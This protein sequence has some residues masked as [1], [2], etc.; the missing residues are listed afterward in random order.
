MVSPVHGG[1]SSEAKGG[2]AVNI[3]GEI[4]LSWWVPLVARSRVKQLEPM[5][6]QPQWG[7]DIPYP[8]VPLKNSVKI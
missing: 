4:L 8:Q 5:T 3:A 7:Q 2:L 1:I 6:A